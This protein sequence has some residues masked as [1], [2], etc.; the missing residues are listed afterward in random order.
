MIDWAELVNAFIRIIQKFKIPARADKIFDED[1]QRLG[2]IQEFSKRLENLCAD[3]EVY[4]YFFECL[5]NYKVFCYTGR[6]PDEIITRKFLVALK[7]VIPKPKIKT[8]I[9]FLYPKN[10]KKN[11]WIFCYYP[12]LIIMACFDLLIGVS[13][14][15][16]FRLVNIFSLLVSIA[17]SIVL[18]LLCILIFIK[19][20]EV[21]FYHQKL[22]Q[23]KIVKNP[24]R[25]IKMCFPVL[26]V[27][28]PIFYYLY[29]FQ[30]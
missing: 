13:I 5:E 20:C 22:Y 17:I 19:I 8:I 11:E 12:F 27:S 29:Q 1:F 25:K 6:Y 4:Q 26:L 2:K 28:I 9:L 7:E 30:F 23:A 10:S 14:P 15:A 21:K 16:D 24:Y 18:Y 3:S